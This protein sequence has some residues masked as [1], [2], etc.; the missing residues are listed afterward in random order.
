M[1]RALTISRFQPFHV[2][3]E[4]NIDMMRDDGY[5]EIVIG[6]GSAE[7]SYTPDNPFTCGERM[8]MVDAAVRGKG[9]KNYFIVPVRDIGDYDLWA[10]HVERLMP[11][12]DAVYGG[13]PL[14][15]LLLEDKGYKVIELERKKLTDFDKNPAEVIEV[16]GTKIRNM[17]LKDDCRWRKMVPPAVCKKIEEYGG[18]DRIKTL[19]RMLE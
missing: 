12:F 6:I 10:T 13:N 3:H 5:K 7:K 17:I 2:G 19:N 11:R 9:F 15:K 18:V 8:E 1:N 14:M 16:S 4:Q